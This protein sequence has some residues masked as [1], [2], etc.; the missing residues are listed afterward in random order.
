MKRVLAFVLLSL[1]LCASTEAYQLLKVPAFI[2]HFIQH[3]QEDPDTTLKGFLE[4]HYADETVFDDDWMQDMGLPFKTCEAAQL[5]VPATLK[6]DAVTIPG[7]QTIDIFIPFTPI[8]A[9]MHSKLQVH[10]IFQPPRFA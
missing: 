6:T 5:L 4:E 2:T 10:K 3:C 9:T 8:L 7:P 1:Y